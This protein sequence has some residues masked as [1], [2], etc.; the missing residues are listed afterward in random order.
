MCPS[1][2]IPTVDGLTML[3]IETNDMFDS[4]IKKADTIPEFGLECQKE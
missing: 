1:T 4:A 2:M 3:I